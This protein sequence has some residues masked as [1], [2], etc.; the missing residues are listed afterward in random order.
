METISTVKKDN[1]VYFFIISVMSREG[2]FCGRKFGPKEA[3]VQWAWPVPAALHVRL[4]EENTKMEFRLS[5]VNLNLYYHHQQVSDEMIEPNHWQW[6]SLS[7][8]IN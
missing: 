5:M 7:R 2:E 1:A 4:C 8:S 6:G 3:D